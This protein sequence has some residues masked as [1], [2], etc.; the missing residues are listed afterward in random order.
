MA[1]ATN[2]EKEQQES[3]Q[4]KPDS[5]HARTKIPARKTKSC[6]QE[7]DGSTNEILK[8]TWQTKRQAA[9]NTHQNEREN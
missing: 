4:P 8:W 6:K 3:Q 5:Q 9:M 2:K 1:A 7:I